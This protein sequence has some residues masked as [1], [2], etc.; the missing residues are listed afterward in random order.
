[1]SLDTKGLILATCSRRGYSSLGVMSMFHVF[2]VIA[3]HCFDGLIGL[4][5]P[6]FKQ[7][8]IPNQLNAE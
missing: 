2:D 5:I 4:L 6:Y 8:H 7:I 1:M 3:K